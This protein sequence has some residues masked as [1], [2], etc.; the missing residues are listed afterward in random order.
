[1]RQTQIIITHREY[2]KIQIKTNQ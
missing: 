2:T 1:M